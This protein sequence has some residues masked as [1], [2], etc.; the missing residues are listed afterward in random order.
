VGIILLKT[1]SGNFREYYTRITGQEIY[2]YKAKD[3]E[4]HEFMHSLKGTFVEE[5]GF[6]DTKTEEGSK[7]TIKIKVSA[8]K[9]RILYFQEES[10]YKRWVDQLK[11]ASGYSNLMEFY[12]MVKDVGKG[13]FGVVKLASHKKTGQKVAIKTIKKKDMKASALELQRNEIEVLKVCQHPNII[14]M[15][16]VF[17]SPDY[18]FIVLE[19]LEGG[20]LF[21]YLQR[22]DFDINEERA[23]QIAH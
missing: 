15:I 14:R 22:R 16:D 3:V 19:Y 6:R 20:D 10:E 21:D 5:K 9:A 13:Q 12:D 1:K 8:Q 17:E 11:R 4:P 7:W 18:F 23:R 2:F